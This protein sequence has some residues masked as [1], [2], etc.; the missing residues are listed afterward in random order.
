MSADIFAHA[1]HP[2]GERLRVAPLSVSMGVRA[3]FGLMVLIGVVTFILEVN[4]DPTRAYAAWLHNYW[5]FLCLGLAGTFFTAIHYLTGATWSVAVRRIADA[6][7]SFV[8]IAALL[9]LIVAVGIPH[10][11]I[12]SSPA[13]TQ[14]V[15]AKLIAKGGYLSSNLYILRNLA[16]LAL[17]SFFSWFFVR[18][19]TRQD[20]TRDVAL[21]KRNLNFSAIFLVMFALS[22]TLASF[23]MLMSLEPTW[24]STI[25]GVYCWSGLWQSGLAAIAIVTVILRRQ[26]ALQGVVSRAHYHDLGKFVFAFGVFW[27][28]IGFSQFMLIWYANLPEEIEWMI[29]RIYTGWGA[30]IIAVATLKFVIP[31]FV[32]M[33]QRW[34]ENETVLLTV[35][36]GVILGQWLDMY[37]V[38]YPAFSPEHAVLS[39]NEIGVA[40]GFLGLFG[41][42]VQSFLARHPVAPHGDP[43][44]PASVRFHG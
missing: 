6:F 42:K 34:K 17:W 5:V 18:N 3:L 31:F 10:I 29:H 41:W 25:F 39:W 7:S 30:V 27:T 15:G 35:A 40:V 26:G 13:A 8:P 12:W 23:D 38:I 28:Y 37:W 2:H 20:E 44:F 32:L 19:S 1:T 16:C 43:D 36:A 22:F 24:Y 33:P 14:G 9:F 21:S 11:Y 4:T